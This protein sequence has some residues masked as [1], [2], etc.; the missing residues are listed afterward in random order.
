MRYQ[1]AYNKPTETVQAST[2]YAVATGLTL[3]LLTSNLTLSVSIYADKPAFTA[4]KAPI[5]SFS[6][7][8]VAAALTL[9]AQTAIDNAV[10]GG[11]IPELAGAT[12]VA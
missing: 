5:G 10:T 12:V 7:T 8:I 1:L 9:N 11:Q 6:R 4:G 2:A 3:D